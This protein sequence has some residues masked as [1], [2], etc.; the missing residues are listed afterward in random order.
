MNEPKA[1]D[2]GGGIPDEAASQFADRIQMDIMYVRDIR[3]VNHM[4]LG[5]IDEV[6]HLHIGA[7][8][9]DR[10][11]EE[12]NRQ[13]QLAWARPFGYPLRLRTDPDG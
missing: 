7:L 4:I 9:K 1:P 12:V 2:P 5:I 11:P 3:G 10:T 13:F 8:L 6:T